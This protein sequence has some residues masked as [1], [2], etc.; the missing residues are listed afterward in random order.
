MGFSEAIK[1]VL[2]KY[3]DF[4]GRASRAEYWYWTLAVFLGYFLAIVLTSIAR[5]FLLLA[6]LYYLGIIIPSLAVAVRRLHDTGRSGWFLLLGL[7]PLFGSIVLLVFTVMDSTPGANRYGPNPKG[8]GGVGGF[9]GS[10]SAS[11]GEPAQF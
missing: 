10:P 6:L 7:V 9:G 5:P 11:Y 3:A 2:G 1:T 4:S 8:V